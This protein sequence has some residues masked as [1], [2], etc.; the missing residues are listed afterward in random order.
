MPIRLSLPRAFEVIRRA[1][2]SA[3]VPPCDAPEKDLISQRVKV[4]RAFRTDAKNTRIPA[5]WFTHQDYS[6]VMV[7]VIS[8][9]GDEYTA[10]ILTRTKWGNG[11]DPPSEVADKEERCAASAIAEK[12]RA[13]LAALMS[14]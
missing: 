5:G 11:A 13:N 6:Q 9:G 2:Q 4:A 12:V 1:L 14:R 3:G 10:Q 7:R 8:H